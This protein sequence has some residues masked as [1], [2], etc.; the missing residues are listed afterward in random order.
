METAIPKNR[1]IVCVEGNIGSGKSSFLETFNHNPRIKT[2]FEPLDKWTNYSGKNL[3][4]ESYENPKNNLFKFQV[5]NFVTMIQRDREMNKYLTENNRKEFAFI[6]RCFLSGSRVFVPN[7]IGEENLTI[8][9]GKLLEDLSGVMSGIAVKPDMIIYIDTAPEICQDR[10]KIRNREGE[11]KLTL[12]ALIGLD[13]SYKKCKATIKRKCT[14]SRFA[15][16]TEIK[17]SKS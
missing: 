6:E 2:F 7:S 8:C 16:L 12:E 15:F 1:V 11:S 13:K 10:I 5:C 17:A 3:L 9:E 14:I 4:R